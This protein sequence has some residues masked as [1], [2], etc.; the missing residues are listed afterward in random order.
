MLVG[1]YEWQYYVVDTLQ[2]EVLFKDGL[3]VPA[4]VCVMEQDS[5]TSQMQQVPCSQW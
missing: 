5:W 3:L 1:F 4:K 2:V